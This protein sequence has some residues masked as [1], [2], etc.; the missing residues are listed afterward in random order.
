MLAL[1]APGFVVGSIIASF[2]SDTFGRKMTV[3]TSALPFG[4]GTVSKVACNFK[5]K[6]KNIYY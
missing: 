3:L 4:C 1:S 2:I 6:E 5:T